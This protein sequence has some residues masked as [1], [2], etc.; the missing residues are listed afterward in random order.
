MHRIPKIF[1]ASCTPVM[2]A[3]GY[4]WTTNQS[5]HVSHA[6]ISVSQSPQELI[7]QDSSA[8]LVVK[9]VPSK[10]EDSNYDDCSVSNHSDCSDNSFLDGDSLLL[11]SSSMLGSEIFSSA[12][13]NLIHPAPSRTEV[14]SVIETFIGHPDTIEAQLPKEFRGLF[15]NPNNFR[16]LMDCTREFL[17]NQ[18]YLVDEIKQKI[19]NKS[20]NSS[21]AVKAIEQTI[22]AI[23]VEDRWN[24][25]LREGYICSI[26]LDLF[27]APMLTS[28][29][30]TFCGCCVESY[31]SQC[32]STDV[33][34]CRP[35]PNCKTD[36][37][38]FTFERNF[39]ETILNQVQ[40]VPDCQQKRDWMAR[41]EES[42]KI[43]KEREAA[44][45][46]RAKEEELEEQLDSE[47]WQSV[48]MAI[49][50]FIAVIVLATIAVVRAK[51]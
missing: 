26:C 32:T 41:Y 12:F 7:F 2:T 25:L 38:S 39:N 45:S 28:C 20:N 1:K 36:I 13:P 10:L 43:H 31:V 46:T 11:E 4:A 18:S 29:G 19:D 5:E 27:A 49:V 34:V 21:A 35:C 33:H 16:A 50:P 42:M 37:E 9:S 3:A 22:P 40:Q 8:P 51:H 14:D 30:H 47:W 17:N 24:E 48:K 23:T 44:A 15:A 6:D